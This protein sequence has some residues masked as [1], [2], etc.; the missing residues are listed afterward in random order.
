MSFVESTSNNLM[1]FNEAINDNKFKVAVDLC[2]KMLPMF[3]Q[4]NQKEAA[5]FLQKMDGLRNDDESSF[6][7]W[8]EES[9]RFMDKV[10]E[11]I[12]YLSDKYDI[13]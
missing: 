11:F 3:V 2:H 13:N 8:K 7:E 4:L 12:T 5:D 6:P 10:D 1:T 9:I